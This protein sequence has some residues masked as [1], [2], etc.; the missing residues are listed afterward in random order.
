MALICLRAHS[1][2]TSSLDSLSVGTS[3]SDRPWSSPVCGVPRSAWL[4]APIS[5]HHHPPS[6]EGPP[7]LRSLMARQQGSMLV[8]QPREEFPGL[9]VFGK[10]QWRR[11]KGSS[12]STALGGL[13]SLQ[14]S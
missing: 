6:L 5:I 7:V 14:E 2:V 10:W 11:E 1:S 9:R 12:L 13:E 4:Q 8:S 3:C